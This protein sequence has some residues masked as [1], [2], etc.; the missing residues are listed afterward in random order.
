MCLPALV[1]KLLSTYVC[2]Q[3]HD[4]WIWAIMG[5]KSIWTGATPPAELIYLTLHSSIH[6]W[7]AFY[8]ISQPASEQPE[9]INRLATH[10]R[11]VK[12]DHIVRRSSTTQGQ[13]SNPSHRVRS[14]QN[15]RGTLKPNRTFTV[16]RNDS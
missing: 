13:S 11:R 5:R 10:P 4:V 15:E 3:C 16:Y 8:L 6:D 12:R 1:N 14:S 2:S 9:N 7:C